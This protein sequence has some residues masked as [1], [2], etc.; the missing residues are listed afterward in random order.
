MT[1]RS[2]GE[3]GILTQS[4]LP[5]YHLFSDLHENPMDIGYFHDLVYFNCPSCFSRLGPISARNRHQRHQT[6]LCLQGELHAPVAGNCRQFRT[7]LRHFFCDQI[8]PGPHEAARIARLPEEFSLPKK[9]Q[10]YLLSRS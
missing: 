5:S 9:H 1:Y 3:G 6:I 10:E 4:L 2:G 7:Q 8:P